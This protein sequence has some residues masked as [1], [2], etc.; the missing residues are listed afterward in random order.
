MGQPVSAVR[1]VPLSRGFP[2]VSRDDATRLILGSLP[3]R[4]SLEAGQYYA[5]PHNAFW[6]IMSALFDAGPELP[7][8]QR[9]S[10]LVQG[11][12][13][14]WDV[15]EAGAR[16]GSLDSAIDQRNAIPNDFSG[17]FS[18]HPDIRL[19]GFNGQ[20]AARFFHQRVRPMLS[21]EQ[22]SIPTVVLPSTSPA[23][24]SMGFEAKLERW[25][26]ALS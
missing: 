14:L 24:A 2:P 18:R 11:R 26:D 17:F 6:K 8:E 15:I 7:Y 13:A 22:A 12:V 20:T 5:Q 9:L 4:R 3:G 19:I 1:R 23:Y 25:A 10:R 16:P 21:I